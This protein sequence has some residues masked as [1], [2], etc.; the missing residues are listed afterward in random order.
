MPL[1]ILDLSAAVD[2][3]AEWIDA[4]ESVAKDGT[5]DL[6]RR[7]PRNEP[8]EKEDELPDPFSQRAVEDVL[9]RDASEE[10]VGAAERSGVA[11]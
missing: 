6:T 5:K 11:L 4:C 1:L 8:E 9:G 3:Y 7:R 2:V 10:E